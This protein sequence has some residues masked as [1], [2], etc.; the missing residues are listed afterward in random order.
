[1]RGDL[2]EQ[3]RPFTDRMKVLREYE[4]V[5]AVTAGRAEDH[6]QAPLPVQNLECCQ[7]ETAGAESVAIVSVEIHR[8]PARFPLRIA[9]IET[10]SDFALSATQD[11]VPCPACATIRSG[12]LR[13]RKLRPTFR[14]AI[15]QQ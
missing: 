1:M 6:V 3:E 2:L 8:T 7:R 4:R 11:R 13:L 9:W 5:P 15:D 14:I 12:L 10:N